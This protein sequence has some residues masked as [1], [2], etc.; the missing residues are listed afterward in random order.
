MEN[1]FLERRMLIKER[2]KQLFCVFDMG[3]LIQ[4]NRL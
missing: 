1:F 4:D 2:D 3:E